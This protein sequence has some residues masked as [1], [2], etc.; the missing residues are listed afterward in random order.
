MADFVHQARLLGYRAAIKQAAWWHYPAAFAGGAAAGG[1]Y[2][3]DTRSALA[4][5]LAGLGSMYG[6]RHAGR[7]MRSGEQAAMEASRA[8]KTTEEAVRAGRQAAGVPVKAPPAVQPAAASAPA[9]APAPVAAAQQ[10]VTQTMLDEAMAQYRQSFYPRRAGGAMIGAGIGGVAGY[11]AG[12]ML[13][14][15]MQQY[16]A[17][18]GGYNGLYPMPQ[19]PY[20]T[21]PA[22]P[23][24]WGY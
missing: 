3:G 17:R 24:P 11:G 23:Y 1:L 10:P 16:G 6:W 13:P 18:P 12:G 9:P 21:E 15:Q 19:Q 14:Q 2:G 5:G 4:G 7:M 8:G 20:G 22:T